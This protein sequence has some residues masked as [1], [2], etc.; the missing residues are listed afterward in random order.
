MEV[1]D[2]LMNGQEQI[3]PLSTNLVQHGQP[4]QKI[5]GI[6][7]DIYGT[8]FIS[9][10]GDIGTAKKN[11]IKNQAVETLLEKYAI[12]ESSTSIQKIFFSEIEETHSRLKTKGVDFPEVEIDKIWMKVL[13]FTD[14]EIARKFAED[15]ELMVNPVYPMPHLEKL[16][17]GLRKKHIVMGIISNAQFYT[18]KLFSRFLGTDPAITGFQTNLLFYSYMFGY[19]KPSLFMFQKAA[20]RLLAAGISKESVVY[21]GNDML[22]DILPAQ[23]EGFQTALFAGDKRSLRLR[24]DDPRVTHTK[25]DIVVTDLIQLFDYL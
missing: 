5:K 8:L 21:L 11:S 17:K 19:A 10:S 18:P 13:N 1:N 22:N 7:F 15:Y 4:R 16:L 14:I 20:A 6:L 9:R 24:K 2:H 23:T 25:P 12:S 3:L